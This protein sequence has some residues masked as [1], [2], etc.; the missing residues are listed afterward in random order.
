MSSAESPVV[1]IVDDFRDGLE[2]YQEYLL[3]RGYN[4]VAARSGAEA[5]D[6]ARRRHPAVILLD[7]SM[8]GMNGTEVLR[9]L[10]ADPSFDAVPVVAF[11]A[12]ALED[13]RATALL[14]GFDEVIAKPC[15]PDD[16]G[17][18]VDRLLASGRLRQ[19]T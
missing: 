6:A 17:L 9:A 13:E 12:H 1:L 15:L 19:Q 4:V 16:L 8:P 14:N 2:M 10:R 7:L 5:L 3:F 18:A 11:T